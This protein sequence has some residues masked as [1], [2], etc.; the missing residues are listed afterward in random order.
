MVSESPK[1]SRFRSRDHAIAAPIALICLTPAVAHASNFS[2]L[3]YVALAII[4]GVVLVSLIASTLTAVLLV[5][6]NGKRWM[7]W[8]TPVFAA[9]WFAIGYA[10]LDLFK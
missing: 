8:L 1:T 9:A 4:G 7:W 2:G 6:A 5:W 10:L 3:A